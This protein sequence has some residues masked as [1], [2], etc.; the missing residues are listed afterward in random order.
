MR[1]ENKIL[2]F[3]V[4]LLLFLIVSPVLF[5][6]ALDYETVS[7]WAASDGG[8]G[9]SYQQ[10]GFKFNNTFWEFYVDPDD[11][12]LHFRYRQTNDTWIEPTTSPVTNSSDSLE[13]IEKNTDF[14]VFFDNSTTYRVYLAYII[15]DTHIIYEGLGYEYLYFRRG[16]MNNFNITWDSRSELVNYARFFTDLKNPDVACDSSGFPYVTHEREVTDSHSWVS[17]N[18][19]CDGSGTWAHT[20]LESGSYATNFYNALIQLPNLDMGLL[21]GDYPQI[22]GL[23]FYIWNNSLSS[24][25][26]EGQIAGNLN[27]GYDF[28][29]MYVNDFVYIAYANSSRT[30]QSTSYNITSDSW[31]SNI[32]IVESDFNVFPSLTRA[33]ATTLKCFYVTNN[34]I[35]ETE[36]GVSW[37]YPNLLINIYGVIPQFFSSHYNTS[38]ISLNDI[39]ISWVHS[40]TLDEVRFYIY[41]G[42]PAETV[43]W[44]PIMF[45]LGIIGLLS[46]FYGLLSGIYKIKK[47]DYREALINSTVIISIGSGLVLSWLWSV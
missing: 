21:I 22:S 7:T 35:Y 9:F 14:A 38:S 13:E 32:T 45:I 37:S 4:S 34:R 28:D 17:V 33:N 44:L 30:L 40:G 36:L 23:I 10:N 15:Y 41:G 47:K 1:L 43:G 27:L 2:F 8:I 20:S 16:Q 26:R 42:T 24:W 31:S 5:V 25:V 46:I 19:K 6:Y 39:G 12:E 18:D 3:S 11:K 29:V